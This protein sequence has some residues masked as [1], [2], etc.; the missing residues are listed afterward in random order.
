MEY[1]A[2]MLT[3]YGHPSSPYST[4]VRLFLEELNLNYT[5]VSIS[6]ESGENF[7]SAY[8]QLNPLKRVPCFTWGDFKLAESRAILRYLAARQEAYSW[9]PLNLEARALV[10]QWMDYVSIHIAIPLTALVWERHWRLKLGQRANPYAENLALSRLQRE[11]PIL[12]QHLESQLYLCGSELTLADL[13]LFPA[14][15]YH[16]KA[17]LSWDSFPAVQN[18]LARLEQRSAWQRCL[19]KKSDFLLRS[20]N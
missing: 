8:T 19:A 11:L 16:K 14:A 20:K 4:G 3:L 13:C 17:H 2:V 12:E 10:D 6:L 15:S 1:P 7:H 9:Y 5:F 18:W